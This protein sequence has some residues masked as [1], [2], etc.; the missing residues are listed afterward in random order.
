MVAHVLRRLGF[1][2]SASDLQSY[3][4]FSPTSLVDHLLDYDRQP[5]DVDGRIGQPGH[6]TVTGARGGPFSPNTTIGEARQRWLF[7]M[8]H[9]RRPLQEKMALFWHNHFATG[10]SKVAGA[11]T[12]PHATKMM[13]AKASEV[14]GEQRG[15]IELF[16]QYA[17]GNFRDLLIEVARDPAMLVWLDGRQN[18]RQSPQEN[19]ARELMELFTLGVGQF[20]EADVTAAARVFTGWSIRV[21]GDRAD[22]ENSYYQFVFNQGQHD[23]NPKTFSFTIPA[24]GGTTIPARAAADGQ[25]DGL[26]LLDALARNPL[27]ATR[28]A[29]KLYGYLVDEV[30]APDEGLIAAAAN[31][32]LGSGLSIR[33]MVRTLVTSPRFLSAGSTHAHYSWPAEFVARAIRE[34]GAA[35]L[36]ATQALTAMEA[37]GQ[38]LFDPRTVAGWP[39][40]APWFST[41]TSLARMNFAA[42]LAGNQRQGLVADARPH[43]ASPERLIDY[44]V[45][46]YDPAPLSSDAYGALLEYLR[47][48]GSWTGSDAQLNAKVP[49]LVRLVLGAAEYQF[50]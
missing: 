16:R 12:A 36:S 10:Y 19:F 26:D 28:L 18:T 43:A 21:V 8:V 4:A 27:T 47:D 11:V 46:R 41:A 24:A 30:N 14:A 15:Q 40:G 34:T 17:L 23:A 38:T 29:R 5:D 49:G 42:T 13:A 6:L 7:R 32:Y 22:A 37:M 33:A 45:A 39:P 44:V 31:A 35:G 25:Q 2:A 9:T 50:S 3:A 1:G 20:T 48:G